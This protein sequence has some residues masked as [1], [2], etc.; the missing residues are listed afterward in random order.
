VAACQAARKAL[1][2]Q[3]G[4]PVMLR[5]LKEAPDKMREQIK[6]LPV[7]GLPGK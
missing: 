1:G 3:P 7:A 4:H 2:I 5:Y 6:L